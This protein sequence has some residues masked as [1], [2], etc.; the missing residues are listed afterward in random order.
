MVYI[1]LGSNQG[2]RFNYIQQAVYRINSKI[3]I[4]K[5]VS[6]VYETLAQGFKG[7]SFLNAC[8]GIETTPLPLEVLASLHNIENEFGRKRNSKN[9]YT[10][11]TLDLDIILYKNEVIDYPELT[12]P[13]PQMEL[14][15]FVLTPLVEIADN[16][17]NPKNG[18]S[19]KQIQKECE[20]NTVIK[21]WQESLKI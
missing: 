18:K 17:I 11:R 3:G 4:V 13:H 2:N 10:A 21:E 5:S 16:V 9:R 15:Q 1:A 19:I 14:R 6:K 20:N 8:I 7:D 12:I